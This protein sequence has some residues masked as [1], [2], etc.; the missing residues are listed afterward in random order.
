MSSTNALAACTQLTKLEILGNRSVVDFGPVAS[1]TSLRQLD[2][3]QGTFTDL[4]PLASCARLVKL[5]ICDNVAVHDIQVLAWLTALETLTFQGCTKITDISPVTACVSLKW[6]N[7]FFCAG[8]TQLSP[9][10]SC[11]SLVNLH[12]SEAKH[13]DAHT[14]AIMR[15]RGIIRP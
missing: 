5:R 14:I 15:E 8:I 6:L 12:L 7:L 2:W 10:L 11:T 13:V 3:H 4:H 1:C 9:L